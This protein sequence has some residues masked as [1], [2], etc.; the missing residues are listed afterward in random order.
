MPPFADRLSDQ[1]VA[2]VVT[3]IQSSWGDNA[4]PIDPGLVTSLCATLNA[5]QPARAH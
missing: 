2:D 3:F 4:P 5:V 1:E